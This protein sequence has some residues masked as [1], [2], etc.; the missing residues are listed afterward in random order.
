MFKLDHPCLD[1]AETTGLTPFFFAKENNNIIIMSNGRLMSIGGLLNIH[2]LFQDTFNFTARF[3]LG[4]V[5]HFDL[6]LTPTFLSLPTQ[7]TFHKDSYSTTSCMPQKLLSQPRTWGT[8]FDSF[9]LSDASPPRS[10]QVEITKTTDVPDVT[11]ERL[12]DETPMPK[13]QRM[14][15]DASIFVGR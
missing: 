1:S 3:F 12:P 2:R 6:V 10:P 9:I 8:R 4:C 11:T 5:A 14:P 7:P 15:H 13:D